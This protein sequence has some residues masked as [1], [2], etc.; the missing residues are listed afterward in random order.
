MNNNSQKKDDIVKLFLRAARSPEAPARMKR[1]G[2][3]TVS[4][5]NF[6]S[7]TAAAEF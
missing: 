3:G 6:S 2:S 4:R 1:I 5:Q 7:N